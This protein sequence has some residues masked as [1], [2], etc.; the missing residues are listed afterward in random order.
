MRYK[1]GGLVE[2]KM[3]NAGYCDTPCV[4]LSGISGDKVNNNGGRKAVCSERARVPS[5]FIEA[6][7]SGPAV[8]VWFPE[9]GVADSEAWVGG[10]Q[11]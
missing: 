6:Q 8:P 7:Q 2:E 9:W 5:A 3:R 11:C 10:E 4:C 1:G